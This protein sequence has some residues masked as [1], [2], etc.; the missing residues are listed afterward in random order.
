MRRVHPLINLDAEAADL[1]LGHAARAHGLDQVVDRTGRDAVDISLLDHRHQ[2]LLGRAAWFQEAW[3]VAP[4]AELRDLQRD[5]PGTGVPIAV[6]VSVALDLPQRGSRA[7]GAPV[8]ASTSAS[9][10][11][12]AAKA[13]ISRTRSPS[14]CFSTSSISAIL[15]SVIVVSVQVSGLATQTY[16]EDRR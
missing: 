10:I 8:R 9:M 12:S 5:P 11:R 3:E 1:A 2:G 16:S 4:L 13:S 14:A 15:S 7:L 6:A